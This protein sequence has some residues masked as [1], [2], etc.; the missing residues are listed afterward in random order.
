MIG[1]YK[2]GEV[3]CNISNGQTATVH[4]YPGVYYIRAQGAGGG[5]GNYA[6]PYGHG[7]GAGSGAGFKGYIKIL[8]KVVVTVTAGKA[9][10]SATDGTATFISNII[11][12]GGGKAG[13]T[14]QGGIPD[15]GGLGGTITI[16]NSNL[17]KIFY[18]TSYSVKSNGKSG[19]K[20]IGGNSVLTND[21]GGQS[22]GGAATARGA[23]GGGTSSIGGIGGNG[24]YG[25]C[26]I[27]FTGFY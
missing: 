20:Q 22:G 24:G 12:L 19:T 26:L 10:N 18:I 5:G 14:N 27:K 17:N 8:K 21:G 25:E 6:Y 3:L 15:I 2:I 7:I 23:G 13:F 16:D 1:P 11:N 4:L 9:G